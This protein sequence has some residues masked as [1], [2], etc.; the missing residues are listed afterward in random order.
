M[1]T[2]ERTP[3]AAL[4]EALASDPALAPL[5]PYAEVLASREARSQFVPLIAL[6]ERLLGGDVRVGG[7]G[8]LAQEKFRFRHDPA[9]T[10]HTVDVSALRLHGDSER[11]AWEEPQGTPRDRIRAQI[12]ST[13]L[14]LTGAVSP[15]P[16]YMAEEVAHDDEDPPVLRNFLDIFHH[17]FLS[18]IYRS[19]TRFDFALEYLSGGRDAWSRRVQTLTGVDAFSPDRRTRLAPG[20]VLRIAP[21]LATRRRSAM[22]L[23]AGV[24]EVLRLSE[25][26]TR[27]RQFLST[28]APLAED[29]RIKLGVVNSHLSRGMLLGTRVLSRAGKFRISVGPVRAE[30]RVRLQVGGDLYERV[31]GVVELAA[32]AGLEWDLEV[33]SDERPAMKLASRSGSKLGR[34]TWLAG[35]RAGGTSFI[36]RPQA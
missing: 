25:G 9:L 26:E 24:R 19:V 4:A 31:R 20:L 36:V 23:E 27:V 6:L 15:L 33:T 3:A 35:G 10:F 18:L 1:A 28:W 29:D 14:G 5:A 17:R 34:E 30:D 8:P 2:T 22:A 32:P 11:A 16:T 7:D 13:F 21:V 12:T